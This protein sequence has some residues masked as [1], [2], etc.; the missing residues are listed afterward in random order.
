MA[1]QRK[2]EHAHAE[3]T[4]EIMGVRMYSVVCFRDRT[5][6]KEGVMVLVIK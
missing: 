2:V 6:E 3:K 5:V 4:K 1:N